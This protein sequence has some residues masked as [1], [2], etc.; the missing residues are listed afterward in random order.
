MKHTAIIPGPG[1]RRA[2]AFEQNPDRY[3]LRFQR[4]IA[5][6]HTDLECEWDGAVNAAPS[7]R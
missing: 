2:M 6:L 3:V 7:L 1:F 5:Q 4:R